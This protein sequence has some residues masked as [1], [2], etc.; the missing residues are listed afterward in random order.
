MNFSPRFSLGCS[1]HPLPDIRHRQVSAERTQTILPDSMFFFFG[2]WFQR[3]PL[4]LPPYNFFS[5]GIPC[6][7]LLRMITN[8]TAITIVFDHLFSTSCTPSPT[9]LVLRSPPVLLTSRCRP[10]CFLED[11]LLASKFPSPLRCYGPLSNH[12]DRSVDPLL[13]DP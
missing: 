5:L 4:R 2:L 1:G 12:S 7:R 3:A 11:P 13:G 6:A 8:L 9:H 10:S